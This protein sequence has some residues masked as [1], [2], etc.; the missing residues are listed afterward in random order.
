MQENYSI[1][2]GP[3]PEIN[4]VNEKNN[5]LAVLEL[6]KNNLVLSSHDISSG[7]LIVSLAEMSI[8]SGFGLKI[9]KPKKLINYYEY[10]FGEDQG[11]YLIEISKDNLNNFQNFLKKN[12]TYSEIV[13]EVQNDTFQMEE[14]FKLNVKD[15]KKINN[16][17]YNKFNALN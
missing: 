3:P 2:D 11:R 1:Y 13:A 16:E 6:I 12:S 10:L 5:G 9:I 4:L 7:G 14:I 17:W 8:S 15:L